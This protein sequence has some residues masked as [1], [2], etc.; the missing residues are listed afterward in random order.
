LIVTFRGSTPSSVRTAA[1]SVARAQALA[2]VCSSGAVR[3]QVRSGDLAQAMAAY[4]LR[5]DVEHVEPDYAVFA[6]FV[7]NDPRYPDTWGLPRIQ[8]PTAWDRVGGGAGVR[9]AILDTGIAN[10][11]DL[12]GKVVGAQDFVSSASGTTDRHGHG[13]HVAGTVAAV[14]NNNH[15]VVGVAWS[16][17][18]LN[19]KVLGDGGAGSLSSV[20]NGIVW[21]ADNG[22]KVISMS[23]GAN[24]DCTSTIQ[25]AA[26]YAWS[27][28]AVLVAA[29]GNDGQNDVH[30]PANCNRILPVGA[31]DSNDNRAAFSNYGAGVPIAAPGVMIIS[32]ANSGDY[33]WM[34]GTSMATPHVAGVAALVWASAYG[35]G[36]QAVVNRLLSTADRIAGTGSYWVNGRVNAAAAVG[37]GANPPNPTPTPSPTLSPT[38]TTPAVACNPRPKVTITSTRSAPGTLTVG[39]SAGAASSG[40]NRLQ[41]L[42][43]GVST[44]AV[45]QA[46][47]SAPTGQ[48]GGFTISLPNAPSSYSFT[49]VRQTPGTTVTVPLTVVDSC[50][51]W[52][53]FVGGGPNAF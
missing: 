1:H 8:A 22:A 33:L 28:G 32:T 27:K 39:V 4:A 50:G 20:A 26:T 31:T 12:A 45:L 23:L 17:S 2:P 16:A 42:R 47:S 9:V 35:T 44:N 7:P 6:S 40:T 29:A 41:Q 18:V 30:T 43:F 52:H 24:L 25:D 49:I 11:P 19:A 34:S 3:V 53:T 21:A 13:T 46:G 10:H 38:P 36:N 51:E 48:T 5:P 14:A 37:G 15:G